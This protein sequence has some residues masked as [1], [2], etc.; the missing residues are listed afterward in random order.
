MTPLDECNA[1][2]AEF[3]LAWRVCC[4]DGERMSGAPLHRLRQLPAKERAYFTALVAPYED[5]HRFTRVN[6]VGPA[7]EFGRPTVTHEPPYPAPCACNRPVF[8]MHETHSVRCS[9]PYRNR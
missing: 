4:A 8:H 6:V 3:F 2:A 7:N 1:L 5:P 9:R